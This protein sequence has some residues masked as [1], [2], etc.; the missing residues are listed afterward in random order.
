MGVTIRQAAKSDVGHV[1]KFIRDLAE[2]ENL[3]HEVEATEAEI[4]RDLF[5]ATPRVFCQIAEWEG[6]AV[7][8]ALWYYTYSTF[9]GRH[10]IWLE[11]LYVDEKCRGK[12]AG[13]ALMI[14]LAQRCVREGLA[15]FEWWVLNWNQ[16]SIEFYKSLGAEMQDAWTV[17]RVDGKALSALA[18]R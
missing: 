6:E 18:K 10:G 17:C 4:T 1:L 7:G 8:F 3:S 12:G 13:K 16:P 5:A 9:R 15:R 14:D 11:D 2:Y